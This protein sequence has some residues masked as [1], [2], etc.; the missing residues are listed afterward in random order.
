MMKPVAQTVESAQI[1]S[2][3]ATKFFLHRLDSLRH[4][5]GDE[6]AFVHLR[7]MSAGRKV[8]TR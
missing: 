6:I 2:N 8:V 5:A 7:S 4:G 1:N 3:K